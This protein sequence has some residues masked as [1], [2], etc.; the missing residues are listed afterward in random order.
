MPFHLPPNR[1]ERFYRGGS[2]LDEFRGSNGG[3]ANKPEDWLASVIRAW[4]PVGE[5]IS[6]EGL[7]TVSVDGRDATLR[8]LVQRRDPGGIGGMGLVRVA[9]PTNGLLTKLIHSGQRLPVHCH[10]SRPFAERFLGS[11]FGKTE[12]WTILGTQPVTVER[13]PGVWLGFRKNVE[14]DELLGWIEGQRTSELLDAMH[15]RAVSA[16][17]VWFVPA[18]TP[19]AIGAGILMME[20]QEPTDFSIVAET[21]GYPIKPAAAHLGAGWAVMIDAFDRRGYSDTEVDGL[22]QSVQPVEGGERERL[23][24]SRSDPF[25]RGERLTLE[26]GQ[27][28]G[29][30]WSDTFV[31]GVV[32][33]G[34][35]VVTGGGRTL[36]LARGGTFAVPA[37]ATAETAL[38]AQERLIVICALP[39]DPDALARTGWGA[40]S[41]DPFELTPR[42]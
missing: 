34:R 41:T 29:L 14:R 15:W 35:G 30:P 24:D 2:L 32:L 25:F 17:D 12:G 7:T 28:I 21:D 23:F 19:H 31:V 20:L 3:G 26:P 4:T 27:E 16:G 8:E 10:P 5:P 11:R 13:E 39:P 37:R 36:D 40:R 33:E 38:R 42:S 1:I 9:G 6:D 18:G 22:R